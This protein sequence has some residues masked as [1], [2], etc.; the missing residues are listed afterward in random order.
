[1]VSIKDYCGICE[2]EREGCVG[3]SMEKLH[4][5]VC[6]DGHKTRTEVSTNGRKKEVKEG[7]NA[8][9][10]DGREEAREDGAEQEVLSHG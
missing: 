5:F 6:K 1:M 9:E 8:D 3:Y 4:Y 10:G 7:R 2:C